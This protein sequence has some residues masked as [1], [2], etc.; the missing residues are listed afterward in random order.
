MSLK[1]NLKTFLHV[2]VVRNAF[3]SV[4]LQQLKIWSASTTSQPVQ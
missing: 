4:L 1:I 3:D 2:G